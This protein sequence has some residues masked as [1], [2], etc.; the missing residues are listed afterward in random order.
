MVRLRSITLLLILCVIEPLGLMERKRI[1][2]YLN[3]DFTV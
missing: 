3:F 2:L 1:L